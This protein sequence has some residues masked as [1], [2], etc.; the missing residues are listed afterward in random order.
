L[1]EKPEEAKSE[2]KLAVPESK[3]I[4]EIQV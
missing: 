1:Q 4:K 2:T 3:L